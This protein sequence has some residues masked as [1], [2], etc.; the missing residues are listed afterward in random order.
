MPRWGSH[1]RL[2]PDKMSRLSIANLAAFQIVWFACVYSAAAGAPWL[3]VAALAASLALQFRTMDVKLFGAAAALG[4]GGEWALHAVAVTGYPP[5]A[6]TGEPIPAW[7]IALW[8]NFAST[9][10]ASLAWL[11]GRYVFATMA[12]AVA[13]PV[14][15]WGGERLGA[16]TL[17]PDPAVWI[18]GV[19][20]L[21]ALAT[22]L[23]VWLSEA[24]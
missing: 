3:G 7:M 19:G 4:L 21:W 23:L 17:H 10:K 2:Q 8:V 11:Q 13:G 14:S 16:I 6:W 12:G 5:Q 20:L 15:Y 9:L 24:N 1:S 22:P 18:G